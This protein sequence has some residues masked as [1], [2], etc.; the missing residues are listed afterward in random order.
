MKAYWMFFMICIPLMALS[1]T[2]EM[3]PIWPE[4]IPCENSL[5]MEVVEDERIGRRIS[6]VH[7]PAIEV[8]LPA[9]S[10]R[11]GTGVVICPGGG[12]AILAWD[13]EGIEMAK[14]LNS[15]GISAFVLRYRLPQWETN[16]CKDKVALMDGKRAMRYV[17]SKAKEWK[18][19]PKKIGIMGFSA[20]G[21]LASSVS[22]HFD[23]GDAKSENPIETVSDRPD[24][25]ILIYPVITMDTTYTHM[26]SR[27]NLLGASPTK[28]R[29]SY[30]ANEAQ[31]STQTP[32]A[33]L[34]HANDDKGVVPENSI[35]YYLG[36][37]EHGISAALHIFESGGHGFSFAEDKGTV[38]KWPELCEGW[39]NEMGLL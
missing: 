31:I 16:A 27:K 19:D 34:I 11:N 22:T 20:G 1:Q 29:A 21:H 23:M 33:I 9:E 3:I 12:Y 38:A 32:P 10:N 7:E 26:R 17:R 28:K 14:W 2:G 37:R 6:K 35:K 25:S 15:L 18:L 24:F 36:L 13:W 5:K 4:G 30:Y 39:L 8:Y